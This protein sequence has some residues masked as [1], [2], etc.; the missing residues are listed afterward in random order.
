MR[1]THLFLSSICFWYAAMLARANVGKAWSL[2][3][4][5]AIEAVGG[6]I[7]GWRFGLEVADR[8]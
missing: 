4:G 8:P 1:E 7:W 5:V 3:W 2:F 6:D